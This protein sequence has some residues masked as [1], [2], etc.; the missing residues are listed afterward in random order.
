MQPLFKTRTEMVRLDQITANEA[1]QPRAKIDHV[2][3]HDYSEAMAFNTEFPPIAAFE[4]EE[5]NLFLADGFHRLAAA[6]KAGKE[7]IQTIIH[8]GGG[9]RSAILHSV[10]CNAAH[11]LR[12]TNDDKHRAVSV[13]LQDPEWGAEW[14]NSEI[15]RRCGVSPEFVRQREHLRP[16]DAEGQA[17]KVTRNGK[18]FT[19][20]AKK[21]KEP[22]APDPAALALIRDTPA[23]DDPKQ[24]DQLA[25][26]PEDRQLEAA[27]LIHAGEARSV[28]EAQKMLNRQELDSAPLP[29]G[30]FNVI[31]ADPAWEYDN[32]GFRASAEKK[33]PTMTVEQIKA[34]P[35]ADLAADRCVIFMWGTVPLAREALAV[36]D[37]WGFEYKSKFAWVKNTV[38]SGFYNLGQYEELYIA[39]RGIHVV[40]VTR[41]KNVF[42][43]EAREHSRK[44]DEVI[45]M[46]EE[47]YPEF[48][49]RLELFARVTRPGWVSWGNQTDMFS[50]AAQAA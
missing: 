26:L 8:E 35:V 43:S 41:R 3:I 13:L 31:Y 15:A 1:A 38:V 12:R 18:T 2:L 22:P 47:M 36:L 7:R 6:K 5:G 40:P 46:I 25:A 33:Y 21:P 24:Y 14:N 16:K 28:G 23:G 44:P 50:E 29:D 30:K 20:A 4:D 11:G 17:K 42:D 34:L 37:A 19:Q 39:T 48:K 45:E 32:N 10:G 9:L 49:A 27:G